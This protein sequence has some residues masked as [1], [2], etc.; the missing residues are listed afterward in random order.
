MNPQS[1]TYGHK[2]AKSRDGLNIYSM[3][4]HRLEPLRYEPWYLKI[5]TSQRVENDD[6]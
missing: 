2:K 4:I 1:N 3:T 6:E 5:E